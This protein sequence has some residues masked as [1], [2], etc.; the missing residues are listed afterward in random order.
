M[1]IYQHI[2]HIEN[3][4]QKAALCVI[5]S[6]KGSTPRK[7]SAKMLVLENGKIHGSIGGGALEKTVIEQALDVIKKQKP[8]IFTHALVQD[9]GM[10]CG[11]SVDIYIEPIVNK[12]KLYIF[13]AGHIGKALARLAHQLG[14]MVTVIDERLEFIKE[15]QTVVQVPTI[16]LYHHSAFQELVFDDQT[17]VAV[18][19]HNHAYD[20]EI[21]AYCAKQP[22]SYLGMIG[23]KRK[24]EVAKKMFRE[25]NILTEEDMA[26]IDWPIG[27]PIKAQA[28]EEIAVAILAKL[29]DVRSSIRIPL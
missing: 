28:P 3:T 16:N 20:R 6:T 26:H 7:A 29:I 17:F 24:V 25:G 22:H 27:I 2:N 21:V 12:I 9:L 15:L 10:C 8:S 1:S 14:F 11:G 18:I 19:T 5:V 13:G 4:N 23:S